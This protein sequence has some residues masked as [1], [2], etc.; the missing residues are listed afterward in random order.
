MRNTYK[1]ISILLICCFFSASAISQTKSINL[2]LDESEN[3]KF[4]DLGAVSINN[5][6][7]FERDIDGVKSI[8]SYAIETK[9][10]VALNITDATTLTSFRDQAV[11]LKTTSVV[12]S[13]GT[14]L[15]TTNLLNGSELILQTTQHAL[16]LLSPGFWSST[17]YRYD[18]Q[19][20]TRHDLRGDLVYNLRSNNYICEPDSERFSVLLNTRNFQGQIN[21]SVLIGNYTANYNSSWPLLYSFP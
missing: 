17:V 1:A 7:V 20:L 19:G 15:G 12:I 3:L 4:G 14:L 13:D 16:Y 8:W 11:I 2:I 18:G 9:A 5:H 6:L 21:N 10:L